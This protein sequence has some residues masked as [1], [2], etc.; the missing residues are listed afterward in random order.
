MTKACV[1]HGQRADVRFL[2]DARAGLSG[3]GFCVL[4]RDA[5]SEFTYDAMWDR[6]SHRWNCSNCDREGWMKRL[7]ARGN[8]GSVAQIAALIRPGI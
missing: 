1:V 3:D 4:A 7:A 2:N 5:I 6:R 8:C